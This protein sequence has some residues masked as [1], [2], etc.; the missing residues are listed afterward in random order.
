M[1]ILLSVK[2]MLQDEHVLLGV[3][4]SVVNGIKVF[5]DCLICQYNKYTLATITIS[6]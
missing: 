2:I 1:G 4:L 3:F 6:Q 5:H